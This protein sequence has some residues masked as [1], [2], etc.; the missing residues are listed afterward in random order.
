VLAV[1][2]RFLV[3]AMMAA[4]VAQVRRTMV[5]AAAAALVLLVAT[6]LQRQVVLAV[7]AHRRFQA[8]GR[9]SHQQV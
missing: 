1:E 4:R 9:R 8:L 7:L 3:R 2:L 6:E 5:L